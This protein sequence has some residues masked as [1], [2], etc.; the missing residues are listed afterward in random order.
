MAVACNDYPQA[1]DMTDPPAQRPEKYQATLRNLRQTRPQ[2]FGPFTI[3]EWVTSPVEYFRSC[4]KWPS[5]S[6]V[7]PAV[8]RD[9]EFP[10]VPTLVL[11]GDL[12]S[13]TSPEGARETAAAFPNSTY[14]EVAHMTH[15]AALADYGRC[16]SEIVRRFVRSL[17][18]GDTSC[19]ARYSK[20]RLVD[21]FSRL[22]GALDW[23]GP[24]L[25]TARIASATVADVLARWWSMDGSSG[26]G[27]RGGTFEATAS[28]ESLW[29][30]TRWH[31]NDVRWVSGVRVSGTVRLNRSS[32]RIR[33][34][35]RVTGKAATP[36]ELRLRWNEWRRRHAFARARGTLGGVKV[37]YRF[38]AS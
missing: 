24:R 12:D 34:N 3:R 21:R 13:L 27:L 1:Y 32:G 4:I 14:V 16:A 36:G 2:A 15:V 19:A 18:A 31:L 9:T 35:I 6:R 7:D 26:V 11:A 29:R 5:P 10:D 20:V 8:P 17:S 22:P 30:N 28:A 23:G 38:P 37:S 25:R 33:A